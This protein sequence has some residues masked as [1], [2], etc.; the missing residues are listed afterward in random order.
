MPTYS[1]LLNEIKSGYFVGRSPNEASRKVFRQVCRQLKK[2]DTFDFETINIENGKKYK[3]TGI[4][5]EVNRPMTFVKN[6]VK[7]EF[8]C[9][10]VYT[11][12]RLY[13]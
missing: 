8:I 9:K 5:R 12:R 7:R 10:Y 11:V 13:D 6:G 1:L 4:R 2:I 3:Y